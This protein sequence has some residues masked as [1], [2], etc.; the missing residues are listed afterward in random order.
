MKSEGEKKSEQRLGRRGRTLHSFLSLLFSPLSSPTPSP[1][2]QPAFPRT[3]KP[4][5][6][7]QQQQSSIQTQTQ[8]I[9]I[10]LL[11]EKVKSEFRCEKMLLLYLLDHF[12]SQTARLE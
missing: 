11:F 6:L 12:Y 1:L 2:P 10:Y 7:P 3:R 9:N 5:M 4:R 8:I